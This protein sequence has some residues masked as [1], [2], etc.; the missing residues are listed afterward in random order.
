MN[1]NDRADARY[2]WEKKEP[3]NTKKYEVAQS[4]ARDTVELAGH[5]RRERVFGRLKNF[6]RVTAF[7]AGV[8]PPLAEGYQ[9]VSELV[10]HEAHDD[11][12]D[13]KL[14]AFAVGAYVV[15]RIFR[16]YQNEEHRQA[17]TLQDQM[18]DAYGDAG[19]GA[20][21]A[22]SEIHTNSTILS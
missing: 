13:G 6:G 21:H 15:S 19:L 1:V 14:Y 10:G 2:E 11:V 9:K 20:V 4:L 3:K 22:T 12:P 16:A 17:M 5:N 18:V 7:V 8:L